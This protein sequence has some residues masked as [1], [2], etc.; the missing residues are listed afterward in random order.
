MKPAEAVALLGRTPASLDALLRGL[1]DVWVRSGEGENTWNAFEILGHLNFVERTDWMCRVRI[2]LEHGESRPFDPVDR[3]AQLREGLDQSLEQR[4]D[5][6]ARL[7][8][9]SLEALK[10][11]DLKVEDLDRRG[12]HP[13]FGIVTLSQLL[14]T[15]AAHDLSHLHQLSRVMAYQYRDAVGPWKAYLGVMKCSGHSEG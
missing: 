12:W 2:I 5:E 8:T 11:L 14:A 13:A 4:L 10:A 9:E 1:P 15:W 6:F 7:R 3:Q